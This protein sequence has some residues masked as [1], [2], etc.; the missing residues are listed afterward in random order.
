MEY[1]IT[2][3]GQVINR[4]GRILKPQ[5][6]KDGYLV[7]ELN[8]KNCKVH[9]LVAQTYIPNPLNLP[10]VNHKDGNKLNN[11]DWNL[12]WCTQLENS[13]HAR[14]N[15]LTN[16]G[17]TYIDI[18]QRNEILQKYASGIYTYIQLAEEYNVRS[19]TIGKILH[20]QI[21][22]FELL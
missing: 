21:K 9:R 19:T 11:N 14:R 15:N 16:I 13:D 8:E 7:I 4:L 10:V 18:N 17:T 2:R 22:R 5:I 1:Q 6:N 12:E 20:H 3:Q